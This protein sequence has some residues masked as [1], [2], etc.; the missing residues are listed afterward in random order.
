MSMWSLLLVVMSLGGKGP[1]P[2]KPPSPFLG[3]GAG[4]GLVLL[5][6]V[7][8]WTEWNEQPEG[9][10]EV[11]P[12]DA[13]RRWLG[14]KPE[15]FAVDAVRGIIVDVAPHPEIQAVAGARLEVLGAGRRCEVE[16]VSGVRA[17]LWFS[18]QLNEMA[19]ASDEPLG[20][21]YR[22]PGSRV[23]TRRK[24]NELTEVVTAATLQRDPGFSPV[25]WRALRVKTLTGACPLDG[26]AV[27]LAAAGEGRLVEVAWRDG[28]KAL[29]D[30]LR[31]A[32]R[33]NK[34]IAKLT[35]E[36]RAELGRFG[37]AGVG[38]QYGDEKKTPPRHL[39]EGHF[40]LRT[41]LFEPKSGE[42]FALAYVGDP[43]SYCDPANAAI[44]Y[45]KDKTKW[46]Q[47]REL[48]GGGVKPFMLEVAVED[49]SS[50]RVWLAG[51]PS[52]PSNNKGWDFL[53]T[54]L[55]QPGAGARWG[56]WPDVSAHWCNYESSRWEAA[57]MC[58]FEDPPEP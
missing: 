12:A 43:L 35:A 57:S 19:E 39:D 52:V 44:V 37:V 50:G 17:I 9:E 31:P 54:G 22:G 3:N 13:N 41:R 36:Y 1:E 56:D 34:W 28:D 42:V 26:V 6:N 45:R 51:W 20:V 32:F 16:V 15:L 53:V 49:R 11:T 8:I 29:A 2:V 7:G 38:C 33:A 47:A 21:V 48:W 23:P 25:R 4:D 27:E 30:A 24:A 46:R 58:V 55:G 5:S 40:G 14:P 10:D 18:D